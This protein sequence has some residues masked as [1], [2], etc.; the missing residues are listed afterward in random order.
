MKFKIIEKEGDVK[1]E[2]RGSVHEFTESEVKENYKNL[3]RMQKEASSQKSL[4][5]AKIENVLHFNEFIKEL[6]EEQCHAVYLYQRS[7]S[8]SNEMEKRLADIEEAIN[9]VKGDVGKIEEQTGYKINLELEPI[10]MTEEE[11]NQKIESLK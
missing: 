2:Q 5:D 9:F 6:T 7:R 1:F 8:I 4:E 3:L 11:L 10:V